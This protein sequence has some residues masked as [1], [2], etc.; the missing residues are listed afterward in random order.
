VLGV[1]QM[2][3]SGYDPAECI[4]IEHELG[5]WQRLGGLGERDNALR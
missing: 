1:R 3:L 4:A 2:G 5:A